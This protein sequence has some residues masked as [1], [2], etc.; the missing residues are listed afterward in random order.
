MFDFI[1]IIIIIII[2]LLN[3]QSATKSANL[4]STPN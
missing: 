2:I 3:A 4:V 1:I